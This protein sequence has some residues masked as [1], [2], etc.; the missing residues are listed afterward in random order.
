MSEN[1]ENQEVTAGGNKLKLDDETLHNLLYVENKMQKEISEIY[2]ISQSTVS[3]MV[4]K[5]RQLHPEDFPRKVFK[6]NPAPDKNTLKQLYINEKKSYRKIA[7][8]YNVSATQ[9]MY[10]VREAN[11]PVNRGKYPDDDTL[12]RLLYEDRKSIEEIAKKYEAEIRTV[13]F[14]ISQA[15]KRNPKDFPYRYEKPP[16]ALTLN[17]LYIDES[18]TTAEIGKLYNVR[19]QTVLRWLRDASKEYPDLLPYKPRRKNKISVETLKSLYIDQNLEAR[20]IAEIYGVVTD[21]VKNWIYKARIE[22]P[23]INLYKRH[24]ESNN[25]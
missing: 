23:E 21:T 4:C 14:W 6:R 16:D 19:A 7:K 24:Q 12:H 5:A 25:S 2:G 18:K 17:K 22:H 1:K 8:I 3:K 13:Y 15:R 10:W 9:V 11:L 20:E